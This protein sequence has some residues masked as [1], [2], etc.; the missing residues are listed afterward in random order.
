MIPRGVCVAAC[1][2]AAIVAAGCGRPSSAPAVV[3]RLEP[4]APAGRAGGGPTRDKMLAGALAVLD[5][6]DDFDEA[7]GLELVF[8]RV[9]QWSQA[10]GGAPDDWRADPLLDTLPERLRGPAAAAA[11]ESRAFARGSDVVFLRDQRWLADIAR[12]NR[13]GAIDDVAIA[14]NLFRWVVRSLALVGDPPLVP[15]AANPGMRWFLPGEILLAGRASGPQRAWIFLELLR[16]AG[17]DGM[18]LATGDRA[19]GT[20]RPWV[21]AVLI[22][23]EVYLFEPTYGMPIPGPGGS[24]IATLRQA[25]EDPGVLESLSLPDRPYPL[26]AGDMRS[27][28]ALVAADPWSLSRRM[29]KLDRHLRT[30]R[31]MRIAVHASRVAAAATRAAPALEQTAGLWEFPWE[32]LA[33]READAAVVQAAVRRELAPLD[34]PVLRSAGAVA[35]DVPPPP[36]PLYAARL[37]EFRGELDGPTGAKT[38]Y[39]AARPG[40]DAVRAA[41]QGMPQVQAD[42]VSGLYRQMKE[43]ATYWLG[44]LTL[45]EGD[46][47]TA[48]EYLGRMTL[49]AAPDSRW[50]DA[51]RANLA[52]ALIGLG[53]TAEAETMLREDLS[54][55]RFGSRLLAARLAA[56]AAERVPTAP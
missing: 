36:R 1:L 24:G 19:A 4:P 11:L 48:A 54:P 28:T 53:R 25:A 3:G 16:H 23:G 29:S 43:D 30:A 22:D 21:P 34:L 18:M 20:L 35:G 12:V 2:V 45:A 6:L 17:L 46:D 41:V 50:A 14:G 39:M 47:A 56:A 8:D 40:R 32:T 31:D 38:A 42:G 55:Q 44:V 26:Q 5:R 51:A 49:E 27:L 10:A 15:T 9:N 52:Q 33:R 13:G 37:R 7:R